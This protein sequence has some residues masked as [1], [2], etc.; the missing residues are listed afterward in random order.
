MAVESLSFVG[1]AA[2]STSST[3]ASPP[4]TWDSRLETDLHA[5]PEFRP[6]LSSRS[7]NILHVGGD[8]EYADLLQAGLS[9]TLQAQCDVKR[10]ARLS[11]ALKRLVEE[12]FD[13]IVVENELPDSRG[14]ATL[15]WL[16]PYAQQ[17]PIVVVSENANE[18]EAM[19]IVKQ[20]SPDCPSK[21]ERDAG[22]HANGQGRRA[23][24]G[25]CVRPRRR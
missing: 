20:G 22:G 16:R 21:R 2:D 14:L 4:L 8:T 19:E 1:V 11:D 17:A 18:S 5:A 15:E 7:L 13:A 9:A 12:A 24:R 25:G 6:R 10:V 3:Y 23:R